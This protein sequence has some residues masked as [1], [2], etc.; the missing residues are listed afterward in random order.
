VL[1]ALLAVVVVAVFFTA[2]VVIV[3]WVSRVKPAALMPAALGVFLAKIVLLLVLV[4]ALKGTTVLD[5]KVFGFAAIACV[6]VW[7]GGQVASLAR[8][9]PYVEPVPSV[10]PAPGTGGAG[11]DPGA[12]PAAMAGPATGARPEEHSVNTGGDR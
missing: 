1:G 11:D 7:T 2:S 5:T 12:G 8:R 4:A 6:L 9:M 3:G 10:D